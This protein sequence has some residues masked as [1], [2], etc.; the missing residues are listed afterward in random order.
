[1]NLK[2]RKKP[3]TVLAFQMTLE[4]MTDRSD[5]PEYLIE[6]WGKETGVEGALK[7]GANES[8][9]EIFT[10]EG[11]HIVVPDAFIVCGAKGEIWAVRG[12]IFQETYEPVEED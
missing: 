6:A 5:W 2:Y 9:L 11:P 12:D 1:M 7:P 10:L 3:V 8:T 4:R